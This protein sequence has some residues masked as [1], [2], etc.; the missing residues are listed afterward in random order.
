MKTISQARKAIETEQQ[1]KLD[2]FTAPIISGVI[3]KVC[4]YFGVSA[5]EVK[6]KTRRQPVAKARQIIIK[7]LLDIGLTTTKAGAVVNRDHATAIHAKKTVN[8]E[9]ILTDTYIKIFQ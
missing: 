5:K 1:K 9:K 7:R 4:K 6:S 3:E 2:D 8:R